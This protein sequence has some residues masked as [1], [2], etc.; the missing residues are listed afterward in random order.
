M[1][2]TV[3]DRPVRPLTAKEVLRMV[4][5]GI[6]GEDERVELLHGALTEVSP[7]SPEHAAVKTRLMGWL[8]P[9]VAEERFVVRTEDPL[10][11]PDTT[12]LPEPDLAVVECGYD[13]RRHPTTALLVIEV[14]VSSLRTDTELKR[15]LYA[16]AAVPEYWVVDV[17]RRRLHVFSEPHGDVYAG[18][19]V[20]G[21]TGLV[22]PRHVSVS[23]LSL[24][25]LFAGI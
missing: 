22:Q 21:E 13:E 9:G 6:I 4:E 17:S 10:V 14:A 23:P 19:T 24:A 16:A 2:L 11:V 8:S 5:V 1:A 7:K 12:S 18:V 3:A 15:A 25:S 20:L